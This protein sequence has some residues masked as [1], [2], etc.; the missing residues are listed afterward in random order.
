MKE[1][2]S[3]SLP[4]PH[5]S[6]VKKEAPGEFIATGR[7]GQLVRAGHVPIFYN[8]LKLIPFESLKNS[9]VHGRVEKG[10]LRYR[11]LAASLSPISVKKLSINL[12]SCEIYLIFFPKAKQALNPNPN[13]ETRLQKNARVKA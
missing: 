4:S 2:L 10:N 11:P 6:V 3:S 13:V 8:C 1:F 5:R 7:Y 12:F 9:H